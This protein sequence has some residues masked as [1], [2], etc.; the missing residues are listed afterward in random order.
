M[1]LTCAR[2]KL[3]LFIDNVEGVVYPVLN[4]GQLVAYKK[5]V[6]MGLV[7]K[8]GNVIRPMLGIIVT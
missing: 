3:R 1:V 8:V 2:N 4:E 6:Y 7:Q 5:V